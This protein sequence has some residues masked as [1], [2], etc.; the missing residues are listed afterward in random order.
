MNLGR[1]IYLEPVMTTS[2]PIATNF[3]KPHHSTSAKP[4]A[5]NALS[6]LGKM[7]LIRVSSF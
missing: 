4:S 6:K 3:N 5:L 2:P 7:V 1:L